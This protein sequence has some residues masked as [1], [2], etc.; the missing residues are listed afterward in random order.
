MVE[1]RPN[2]GSPTAHIAAN[3]MVGILLLT[4]ALVGYFLL[5]PLLVLLLLPSVYFFWSARGWARGGLLRDK[6]RIRD[7]FISVVGV[8]DGE[9]I[10]D[11]GTGSGFLAIGFAKRMTHGEVVGIDVWIPLGGGTSMRNALR[12]AEVEGVSDRVSFKRADARDIPYPDDYFDRV[13]A[14]FTIHIIRGWEKAVEEMVRVLKPGGVFAVL[15][16]GRGW[17]GG[18]KVDQDLRR[19]L[20][21]LGLRNVTFKPFT[22]YYPKKRDVYLIMGVK[23]ESQADRLSP[24]LSL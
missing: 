7:D 15:E 9:K 20:E 6:L 1:E 24:S 2:Y 19:K 13:V 10:L 12:N 17:A 5:S 3:F 16:P 14:S 18:W 23:G 22:V 11:V 4:L 21:G 8:E